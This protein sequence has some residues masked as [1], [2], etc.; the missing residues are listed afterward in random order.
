MNILHLGKYYPP[1]VGGIE[2]HLK[3]LCAGLAQKGVKITCAV[4][5]AGYQ[6][7]V[8]H[9]QGMKLI[10]FGRWISKPPLNPGL[11]FYLQKHNFDIVHLHMPNP[12]A[13]LSCLLAKPKKLV[14]SY[15]ADIVNKPGA[16][17]YLPFQKMLLR[18]ADK[19]IVASQQYLDSSPVLRRFK[20]KCV[21]IPYG[22]DTARFQRINKA[23]INALKQFGTPRVLYVGRLVPYK[24][25]FTLLSAMRKTT[26][27]LFIVG[28]GPLLQEL[29]KT[30]RKHN[31]S[32]RV[33]FFTDVPEADLPNFYHA[34]DALVLPSLTRAESFGIVQLE[35]MACGKP[36]I[37]TRLNTGVDKVNIHQ[38]T[39]FTVAPNNP[40]ALAHAMERILNSPREARK[41]GL[42]GI[43]HVREQFTAKRMTTETMRVYHQ[44]L[45]EQR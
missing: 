37:S 28:N 32:E 19:I 36:L 14:V 5:A 4:S 3:E 25:L 15:H 16:S 1:T 6:G 30:V 29:K 11:L 13:E 2:T 17:I 10:R 33:H 43:K 20:D 42:Q 21:I 40:S 39:G 24:G 7:S 26:G 18:R 22:I 34:A 35:A 41:L 31:L 8:E 27:T 44:V 23:R 12:S 45:E 9:H 38:K